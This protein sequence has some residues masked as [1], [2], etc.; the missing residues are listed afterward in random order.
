M[1][2]EVFPRTTRSHGT[3][4]ILSQIAVLFAVQILT[5]IRGSRVSEWRVFSFLKNFVLT[6]LN[7]SQERLLITFVRISSVGR[8]LDYR[9]G[10]RGFDS[11]D[12]RNTQGL[13]ITEK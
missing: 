4:Q 6:H 2:D 3:V 7:R 13:K 11:R 5:Q 9:A 12:Q 8:A 10:G 1:K